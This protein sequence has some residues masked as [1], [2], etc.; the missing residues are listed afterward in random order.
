MEKSSWGQEKE[1]EEEEE[2]NNNNKL[3]CKKKSI[4]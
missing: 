1:E 2:E 4:T 3:E